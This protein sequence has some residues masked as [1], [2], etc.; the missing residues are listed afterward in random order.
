MNFTQSL[1]SAR[2]PDHMKHRP[3]HFLERTLPVAFKHS[4]QRDLSGLSVD[5]D[6][7]TPRADPKLA[8]ARGVGIGQRHRQ[9]GIAL[10][11][12][13]EGLNA[14]PDREVQVIVQSELGELRLPE[15]TRER[16]LDCLGVEG[17]F[18]MASDE[19]APHVHC[20]AASTLGPGRPE[21]LEALWCGHL[22]R[23]QRQE[24]IDVGQ[25]A[26]EHANSPVRRHR[27]VVVVLV[28]APSFEPSPIRIPVRV[29][30]NSISD[31]G[32]FR[33]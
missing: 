12:L 5:T 13:Y 9:L 29:N 21:E 27:D 23:G 6:V 2:A 3:A 11:A 31:L 32:R 15:N 17:E 33:W 22:L 30:V 25:A 20:I 8:G 24:A 18:P 16:S 28:G 19:A 7:Q 26:L 1:A 14:I 10:Q 4:T